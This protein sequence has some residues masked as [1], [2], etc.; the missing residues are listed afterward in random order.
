MKVVS[1]AVH[2]VSIPRRSPLALAYATRTACRSILLELTTD[3]GRT[4]WGEAVPVRGGTGERLAL[5]DAGRAA[6][7]SRLREL[8][9]DDGRTGW[10]E[11]VPVREVTGERLADVR[12]ALERV[13][14][15]HVAG[16]DP[17]PA[18]PL[19]AVLV[20]HLATLPSA[21]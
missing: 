18:E 1:F 7:R 13:C 15:E 14:R 11:A 6:C 12:E 2:P 20:R 19:R 10:G 21:R 8:T 17:L 4:G 5:A 16:R 3:D 9:T